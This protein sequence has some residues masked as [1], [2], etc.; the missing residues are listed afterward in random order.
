MKTY[1]PTLEIDKLL[2]EAALSMVHY[3]M[4]RATDQ[5]EK[6]AKQ[7]TNLLF[8]VSKGAKGY[9]NADQQKRFDELAK[10]EAKVRVEIEELLTEKAQLLFMLEK[11]EPEEKEKQQAKK[12]NKNEQKALDE[13]QKIR[14]DAEKGQDLEQSPEL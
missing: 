9:F 1:M 12:A 4:K 11:P 6:I 7:R 14:K 10:R 2:S 13:I 8:E 3:Q 5:L